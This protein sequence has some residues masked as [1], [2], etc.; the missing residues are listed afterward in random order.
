[1]RGRRFSHG[2]EVFRFRGTTL[3]AAASPRAH[4]IG[5][6]VGG[7]ERRQPWQFEPSEARETAAAFT[8]DAVGPMQKRI[9][10]N[11]EAPSS[12]LSNDARGILVVWSSQLKRSGIAVASPGAALVLR[13]VQD[14]PP[15]DSRQPRRAIA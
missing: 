13:S 6:V 3:H 8:D 1:V 11:L 14:V 15:G 2:T 9:R 4:G 5:G 12:F 10:E 7:W